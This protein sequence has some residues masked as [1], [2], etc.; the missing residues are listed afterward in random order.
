MNVV[1]IAAHP[2]AFLVIPIFCVFA[3]LVAA[4]L[5]TLFVK[6]FEVN[7]GPISDHFVVAYKL[8]VLGAFVDYTLHNKIN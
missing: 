7:P 6:S 5:A 3:V 2:D 8:G 4:G 1:A